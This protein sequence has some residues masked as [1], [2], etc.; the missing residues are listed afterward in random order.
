MRLDIHTAEIIRNVFHDS[1]LGTMSKLARLREGIC[2]VR[3]RVEMLKVWD[4]MVA[5]IEAAKAEKG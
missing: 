3:N 5:Y 1:E 2:V 4:A